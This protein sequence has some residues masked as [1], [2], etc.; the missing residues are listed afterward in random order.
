MDIEKALTHLKRKI[1]GNKFA[2][3]YDKQCLNEVIAYVNASERITLDNQLLF[4]KLYLHLYA[5][6][7]KHY[8]EAAFDGLP[9]KE[10]HRILDRSHKNLIQ[11]LTD[12]I[13]MTELYAA[14]EMQD[15]EVVEKRK[16]KDWTYEEVAENVEK[17]MIKALH[18]FS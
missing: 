11:E 8:E 14:Y 7:I 1:G 15:G 10:L 13:N 16:A 12:A 6:F 17:Q 9:Q 18:K 2:T 4:S 5:E 3:D